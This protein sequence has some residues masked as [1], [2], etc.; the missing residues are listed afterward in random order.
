MHSEEDKNFFGQH[1]VYRDF[2]REI[3]FVHRHY[4]T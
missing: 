2:K 3:T 4:L 1:S